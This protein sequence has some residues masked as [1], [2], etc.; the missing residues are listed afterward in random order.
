[1]RCWG[2][3]RCTTVS[4]AGRFPRSSRGSTR[5]RTW[6]PSP[7]ATRRRRSSGFGATIATG[8]MQKE[9]LAPRVSR[10]PHA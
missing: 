5:P 4:R 1:M 9:D 3:S 10:R 6:R 8:Q 2:R 7:S